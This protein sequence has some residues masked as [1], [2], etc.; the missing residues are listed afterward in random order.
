METWSFLVSEYIAFNNSYNLKVLSFLVGKTKDSPKNYKIVVFF[1]EIK[2]LSNKSCNKIITY[3]LIVKT[4]NLSNKEYK[5]S[6][7]FF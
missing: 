6:T 5:I 4:K 1:P 3:S 7:L 2:D